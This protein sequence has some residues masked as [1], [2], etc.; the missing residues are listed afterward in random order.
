MG[1]R[2][3]TS[4][5]TYCTKGIELCGGDMNAIR[6]GLAL[7]DNP[8]WQRLVEARKSSATGSPWSVTTHSSCSCSTA[9]R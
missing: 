1:E 2:F 8:F 7:E 5:R 9:C 6:I 4:R 3:P